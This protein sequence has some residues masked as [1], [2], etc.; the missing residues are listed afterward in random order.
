[1][2]FTRPAPSF[3][4]LVGATI[5][6]LAPRPARAQQNMF[7]VPTGTITPRGQIYFQEQNNLGETGESQLTLDVGLGKGFE[8]GLN[9]LHVRLYPG[10][11]PF[12]RSDPSSDALT[13]NVQWGTELSS[14]LAVAM[15]TQQGLSAH[16][17]EHEVHHVGMGWAGVRI[18]PEKGRFGEYII[19]AYAAS[20][21]WS[22][23]GAPWGG[24]FGVEAP[25]V[26][27]RLSFAADCM[28]GTN[29]QSV[30]VLGLDI[31]PVEDSDWQISLGAQLPGPFAPHTDYAVI[32]G[33][34]HEAEE[35]K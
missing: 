31:T 27:E 30:E 23:A 8:I 33:L 34:S 21:S 12:S 29:R 19:G 7:N 17:P 22:G 15:G 11:A 5:A 13:G 3:W 24:M 35:K 10:K 1:M 20:R 14:S 9:V 2:S 6:L 16:N 4:A 26:P 25:I 32:L 28:I 18:E